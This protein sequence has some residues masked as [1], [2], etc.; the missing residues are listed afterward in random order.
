M[1]PFLQSRGWG[2]TRLFAD[3]W[4]FRQFYGQGFGEIAVNSVNL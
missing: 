1:G 2:H 4:T 3:D